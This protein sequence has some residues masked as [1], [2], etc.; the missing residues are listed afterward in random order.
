MGN[1]LRI[2][3]RII[4][5]FGP[6][7]VTGAA[8][9]DPS[10]I[11]TYS[12]AGAQF[13]YGQLWTIPV[14]LP[15]MIAIQEM[16]ARIGIVTGRGLAGV[17]RERFHR[18]VLF[19]VVGLL[20]AANVINLGTDLGAMAAATQLLLPAPFLSLTILFALVCIALELFASYRVYSRY[21]KW[22][23]ASL[24]AYVLTGF[25]VSKD[26]LEVLQ[27]TFVPHF[28]GGFGFVMV[29]TG[30][31]G[32]TISPYMFFWQTS[33]E[34][35]EEIV[36]GR[37]CPETPRPECNPT[38]NVAPYDIQ[39]MRIDTVVGMVFSQIATWFIIIT[40]A[41]TLHM[42]GVRDVNTAADA[43]RALEPLV[44]SFPH[45]GELAKAIFAFGI[46]ALGLLAV[47]IFAGSASYALAE[48]FGWR[49]GLYRRLK[50]APQF[51]AI[52]VI[53]SLIGLLV[54]CTQ[55]S[56]MKALLYTAV[57][58]GIAAVPLIYVIITIGNNSEIMG[59]YVNGFW[60]RLMGWITFLGMGLSAALMILYWAYGRV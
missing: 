32:T 55:I 10:G 44:K 21:L 49:E 26:W 28:E 48:S 18:G 47:P 11:A 35:E 29:L 53:S 16:C 40:T 25:V 31:L 51:Y 30:V 22:M 4:Q 3:K 23:S 13:G 24:L 1:V 41:G 46:I 57:L 58:N 59:E 33:Q 38:P 9:D 37:L 56:P 34:V 42:A 36:V 52:I 20:V 15:M 7:V 5:A 6:G 39:S 2:L 50:D 19:V 43:A 54:N 12:Q 17:V 27:A 60:S 45:A 8:D 14:M